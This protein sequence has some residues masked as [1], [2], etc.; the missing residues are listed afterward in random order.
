MSSI[1]PG[2]MGMKISIVGGTGF[3]GRNLASALVS[4]GHAVTALSRAR[5][6]GFVDAPNLKFRAANVG[7]AETLVSAFEGADVV[8]YSVG[9]LREDRA[10]GQ[11][12]QSVQLSGVDNVVKEAVAAGVQRLVLISA[13]GVSEQGTGYQRTKYQAEKI[14][15]NSG[16]EYSIFRPSVIFGDSAGSQEFSWQLYRDIV[17]PPIPAPEFLARWLA[18]RKEVLMSPVAID[19]VV[20]ALVRQIEQPLGQQVVFELGGPESLGWREIIERIADATGRRKRFVKVPIKMMMLPAMLL[21]RFSFFPVTG[22]QLRMLA[23]GNVADSRDLF[24][25]TR[26]APTKF[27]AENL[28]YL[29]RETT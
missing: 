14:V 26:R 18:P 16:L 5:P 22:D 10:I 12:F 3:V 2:A 24:T 21:G 7:N 20:I 19:D 9:L 29:R 13:N 28:E 11:T 1:I 4:R 23:D 27:S 17:R 8:V 6:E 25:L 15:E